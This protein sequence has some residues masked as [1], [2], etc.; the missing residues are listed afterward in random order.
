MRS[1][2][3]TREIPNSDKPITAGGSKAGAFPNSL[4]KVD[5]CDLSIEGVGAN[6][7]AYGFMVRTKD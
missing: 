2:F 5:N 7:T 3:E 1:F 6:F 4:H